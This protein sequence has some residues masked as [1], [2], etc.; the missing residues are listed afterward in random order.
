MRQRLVTSW[1]Y[2]EDGVPHVMVAGE[3]DI[4]T[5]PQLDEVLCEARTQDPPSLVLSLNECTYCD[6]S[7]LSVVLRHARRTAHFI[8]VSPHGSD[9]RRL[10][11]LAGVDALMTVVPSYQ[12]ARAF[13]RA[14]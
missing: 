5:A 2:V 10:F 7:G 3:I 9:I 13:L 4:S 1:T 12:E 8:L 11:R 14:A 6:S